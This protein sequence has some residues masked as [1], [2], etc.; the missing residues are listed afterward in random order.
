MLDITA[1]KQTGSDELS[2]VDDL[3]SYLHLDKTNA[4]IYR[5]SKKNL[6]QLF[7]MYNRTNMVSFIGA[8]TSK[9]LGISDWETLMKDLCAQA[10]IK[11]F[12][13]ELPGAP[14]D[15]PQFAQ[16]IYD[17]L[18]EHGC[19]DHYFKTILSNMILK[20]TSTTA[21]LENLVLALDIHL[22]TNFDK[23]IQAAYDHLNDLFERSN[24]PS[25]K[26][27]YG[28]HYLPDFDVPRTTDVSSIYYLHGNID[29]GIYILKKSD[30]DTFYPSVSSCKEPVNQLE[31]FLK[32]R[33][34]HSNIIF[35]GFS[36]DD[37]Y[38]R[39]FFE[40]VAKEI[41]R[42]AMTVTDFYSQ[43]RKEYEKRSIKHFLVINAGVVDKPGVDIYD[44]F[45]AMKIYPIIYKD[46]QH[47]FLEKL[48]QHLDRRGPFDE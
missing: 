4:E 13:G 38:V 41:D 35:L 48:F 12:N 28:L 43:S 7:N 30:Y 32:E 1:L 42:E 9:P 26:K 46:G 33:Y 15:W 3:Y 24:S 37:Y 8:G 21:T 11:G 25:L 47:I 23:S 17:Y 39:E 45:E 14:K 6:E 27:S 2:R 34:R 36:F 5:R 40:R 18:K 19:S 20:I 29:K 31:N 10:K 44:E 16:D 22:T